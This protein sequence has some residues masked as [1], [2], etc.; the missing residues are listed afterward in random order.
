MS[1]PGS[2]LG[3]QLLA[4]LPEVYRNRDNGDL[5]AYL[6]ACGELLDLVRATQDQLLA[7][8]FP[9]RSQDGRDAQGWILPYLAQLLDVNLTS[10][11]VDGR[12]EEVG[13]AVGWRQRKGT[14]QAVEAIAEAVG[15]LEVEV[16]EG[17]RRVAVTPRVDIPIIPAA[18]FGEPTP[19]PSIPRA[20]VRH[21]GLPAVTPDVTRAARAVL[22]TPEDPGARGT[23]FG[24]EILYWKQ[25]NRHGVPCFPGS[26]DDPSRRTPDL[27]TP[28]WRRGHAHP[29]RAL[30]FAPPP[31]GFFTPDQVTLAWGDRHDPAHE[32]HVE[33]VVDGDERWVTN[34]SAGTDDAVVVTVTT[35][36]AVLSEARVVV[37]D[38]NVD[39]TVTVD[40]GR[41][42]LERVAARRLSVGT[43]GVDE[44]V[45][46]ARD[47]LFEEVEAPDGR[48]RLEYCT[49]R[50]RLECRRIEASDTILAGEVVLTGNAV[51]RR[52]S[53]VR[54]SSI[55]EA[56]TAILGPARR[57][58][59]TTDTPA[60]ADVETCDALG[61]LHR[62][63]D[64]G[65]PGYG[66]LHPAT[67][68]SVCFGAE[69]GGEMG[70]YHHRRHCLQAAAVLEKLKHFLPVGIKAAL[71]HDPRLLDAP[72]ETSD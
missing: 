19:D 14:L 46:V 48:V 3:R 45:V 68:P 71:V 39:A 61:V 7:D 47:C 66:V 8:A 44:P 13:R 65:E 28:D 38:L 21:P 27:R 6:D 72:P 69:D 59:S 20:A 31:L 40:G 60:F 5:S 32:D 11:H 17:W 22:S 57:P 51:D 34:P 12:R 33:D 63:A 29:R 18:A 55:P 1:P 26:F 15:Q 37:T 9:G 36:P 10:P 64:F 67:P 70:A 43:A 2:V 62:S 30:L 24:G 35:N 52:T 50:G 16:Q 25:S 58:K 49:V 54:Y 53:C 56:L 23:R 4:L 41:I 42:E